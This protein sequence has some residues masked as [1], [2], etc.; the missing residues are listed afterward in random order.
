[1]TCREEIGVPAGSPLVEIDGV[2]L[3]VAREG[4]G[5]ALVCLHAVG[6]GAGDFEALTTAL[7]DRFEIVRIDWP[8]QGRSGPDRVPASA[9]RYAMLLAGV[10]DRL[11]LVET[12][13]LGNS[14]GGAAAILYAAQHPVRALVLCDTGGLVPVNALVRT[15]CSLLHRFFAAGARGV[16]WYRP[17]FARYYQMV[18][19]MPEAAAQRRRILAAGSELAPVLAEAW[20]SF[21]R[22]EADIRAVAEALTVPVWFAWGK[23]DRVIPVSQCRPCIERMKTATV[24]AFEAGHAAFLEQPAAFTEAFLGF[25]DRLPMAVKSERLSA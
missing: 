8:G 16:W 19:P 10:I 4:R 6:H 18:L 17:L 11:G 15:V 5:P 7:K 21:G 3:A 13:L 25:V 23:R 22:P 1:M 2:R 14:I 20:A 24:T 12:I 9:A